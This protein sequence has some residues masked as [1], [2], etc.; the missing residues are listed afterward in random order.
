MKPVVSRIEPMARDD[1]EAVLSIERRSFPTPWTPGMFEEEL[2]NARSGLF[3]AREEGRT[4]GRIR[5]YICFWHVFDELHI[6]NLAVHPSYRRQ[7]VA[8]D[9][10]LFAFDHGIRNNATKA[11]LEVRA[12]N[13]AAQHLYRTLGFELVGKRPAYYRDTGEDALVLER[14]IPKNGSLLI[15]L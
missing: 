7:N 6:L 13:S 2:R 12:R 9:L 8:T 3:V 1:L 11:F 14:T 10:L 15:N 4:T 5:G